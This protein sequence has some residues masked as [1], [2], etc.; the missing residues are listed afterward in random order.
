MALVDVHRLDRCGVCGITVSYWRSLEDIANWKRVAE[1][2]EA[3]RG[4]R[5]KWYTAYKTRIARVERD[6][7]FER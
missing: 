6:Y 7:G 3:Q 5:E 2:R 1:H 4:G